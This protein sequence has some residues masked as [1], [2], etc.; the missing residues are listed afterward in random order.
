MGFVSTSEGR[1]LFRTKCLFLTVIP[2]FPARTFNCP[3][4]PFRWVSRRSPSRNYWWV[5]NRRGRQRFVNPSQSE[6]MGRPKTQALQTKGSHTSR[7]HKVGT[8]INRSPSN[9]NYINGSNRDLNLVRVDPNAKKA[10]SMREISL[11]NGV[12][13]QWSGW[14]EESLCMHPVVR[15]VRMWLRTVRGAFLPRAAEKTFNSHFL[16]PRDVV[17]WKYRNHGQTRRTRAQNWTY[18]NLD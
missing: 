11:S 17:Q 2:F 16:S 14:V 5:R 18:L 13:D 9:I 3:G 12:V 15:L 7:G 6:R 10:S 1:L 4:H 8:K